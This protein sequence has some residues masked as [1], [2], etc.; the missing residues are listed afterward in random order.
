MSLDMSAPL[1]ARRLRRWAVRIA[2]LA[3]LGTGLW[4]AGA[5]GA[6]AEETAPPSALPELL[7]ETPQWVTAVAPSVTTPLTD[8]VRPT[9][10]PV[11]ERVVEPVSRRVVEP[12]VERVVTDVVGSVLPA[13]VPPGTGTGD[14]APVEETTVPSSGSLPGPAALDGAAPAASATVGPPTPATVP[15]RTAAGVPDAVLLTVPKSSGLP[16]SAPLPLPAGLPASASVHGGTSAGSD[17]ATAV[18]AGGVASPCPEATS[19]PGDARRH[20]PAEPFF[21]PSF[22]PG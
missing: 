22:S 10:E 7:T 5:S 4:L 12:V 8:A 19:A 3:G 13:V 1:R 14:V 9:T 16:D 11:L 2:V 15:A 17:G 20:T 6:S 21:A 18:L